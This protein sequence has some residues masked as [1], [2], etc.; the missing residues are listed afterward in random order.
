MN[1]ELDWD[2][3]FNVRDLGGLPLTDGAQTKFGCVVRSD[4]PSKAT[5]ETWEGIWHYGIRTVIS[6]QTAGLKPDRHA[7]ENPDL[8]M[9]DHLRI[10]ALRLPVQDA[11]DVDYMRAWADTGLWGTPL[12]F[13]DAL[14]KW[15]SYY[16][17]ILNRIAS[18]N[19]GVL[20]HCVRGHDR[21][22][23]VVALLLSLV[24]VRPEAVIED[25]MHDSV[26]FASKAPD[27]HKNVNDALES[28]GTNL[29]AA[30]SILNRPAT[31]AL[32]ARAGLTDDTLSTLRKKLIDGGLS[33]SR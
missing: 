17:D 23:I 8:G 6:F 29:E 28:A 25:Y 15:P 22:G 21:T 4:H 2:G 1:R 27:A 18:A 16:V 33:H 32:L 3:L 9:P 24:G 7:Q 12:F 31:L 14:V 5:P 10:K 20:L 30:F 11:A 26:R 19:G 13:R